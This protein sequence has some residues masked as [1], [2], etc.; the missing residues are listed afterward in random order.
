MY[1]IFFCSFGFNPLPCS[2]Q[3][4]FVTV[5]WQLRFSALLCLSPQWPEVPKHTPDRLAAQV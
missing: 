5:P 2:T 4:A 3:S 1:T